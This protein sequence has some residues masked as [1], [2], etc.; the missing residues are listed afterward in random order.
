GHDSLPPA[1]EDTPIE[2][3]VAV[4]ATPDADHLAATEEEDPFAALADVEEPD[5]E[6]SAPE[7]AEAPK[8]Q[9]ASADEEPQAS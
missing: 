2:A 3:E 7:D 4:E 9:M 8:D 5:A 6:L 1:T